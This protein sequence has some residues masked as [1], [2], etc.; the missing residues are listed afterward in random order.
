M[1]TVAEPATWTVAV[2][3]AGV[4]AASF[5]LYLRLRP[6]LA[7]TPLALA[8]FVA[9][10]TI[11]A[12]D[13]VES[14]LAI[15]ALT[16]RPSF[17]AQLSPTTAI[18]IGI[19]QAGLI[20]LFVLY[21]RPLP[22]RW[23]DPVVFAGYATAVAVAVLGP[24]GLLFEP[25]EFHTGIPYPTATS[26]YWL[27]A[28][29]QLGLMFVLATRN[30]YLAFRG[31]SDAERRGAAGLAFAL[32]G[33][34]MLYPFI[35]ALGVPSESAASIALLTSM[36][37][38]GMYIAMSGGYLPTPVA[39][40]M[41]RVLHAVPE[42]VL[43]VGRS[44][45]MAFANRAAVALLEVPAHPTG[46]PYALALLRALPDTSV[47]EEVI[48]GVDAVLHGQRPRL[49]MHVERTGTGNRP[50]RLTVDPLESP[51]SEQGATAAVVQFIDESAARALLAEQERTAR[52]ADLVIR[53]LGHDL[54][55]PLAVIQG[56]LELALLRLGKGPTEAEIGDAMRGLKRAEQAA[57]SMLVIMANA[58]AISRLTMPASERPTVQATDLSK[59]VREVSDILRPLAEAKN[60]RLTVETPAELLVVV[61]PGFE[62]VIGNLTT[63]AI[64]YTPEGGEVN[65]RLSRESGVIAFEVADTGPG[66]ALEQRPRLFRRFERL[67]Q[68]QSAKSHGLGL[69]IVASVV[70][71]SGGRVEVLDRRDA[72]PGALFRV[73]I[74]C[75]PIGLTR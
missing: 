31:K 59:M 41:K 8:A 34:L 29:P 58:R 18:L 43:I 33:P 62:S 24:T 47:R 20:Q 36:W 70:E 17:A 13:A 11:T 61:S 55:A 4:A 12:V 64:R 37:V 35:G 52:L 51:S 72:R 23:G 2:A 6:R 5:A 21:P 40:T 63:N 14:V 53:V 56:Y 67:A 60:Q 27:L 73:E 3:A 49:E 16:G 42:A 9:F 39:A 25:A 68:E 28:A 38:A 15:L 57:A 32:W 30:T 22:R 45:E 10:V 74:P 26:T 19:G 44:G 65:V 69:S 1:T 54:K 7:G 66:V 71:L 50:S 48:R 46:D 75:A